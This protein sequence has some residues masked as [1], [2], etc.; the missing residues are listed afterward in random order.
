M[1][2]LLNQRACADF[3]GVALRTVRAWDRGSS[4]V[5]WVVIR[6]LRISRNGDLLPRHWAGWRV[7]DDTL[8]SPEGKAFRAHELSFWGN[9]VAMARIWRQEQRDKRLSAASGLPAPA[10]LSDGRGAM[11]GPLSSYRSDSAPEAVVL[12]QGELRPA[13]SLLVSVPDSINTPGA[14]AAGAG[15]VFYCNKVEAILWNGVTAGLQPIASGPIRYYDGTTVVLGKKALY[16]SG[17]QAQF[18][19]SGSFAR[20]GQATGRVGAHQSQHVPDLGCRELHPLS[21]SPA[22]KKV[23]ASVWSRFCASYSLSPWFP[24]IAPCSFPADTLSR[25][26]GKSAMPLW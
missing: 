6:L 2:C 17:G 4:R 13:E 3:L 15:L 11:D 12:S 24:T 1:S 8:W 14:G 20:T 26:W 16:V 23:A 25:G 7:W 9:T 10:A 5:P 19:S 18:A 21:G 22:S